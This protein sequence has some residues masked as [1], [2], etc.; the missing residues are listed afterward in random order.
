M[1]KRLISCASAGLIMLN[2]EL[3]FFVTSFTAKNT[4][5]CGAAGNN[6]KFRCLIKQ[7]ILL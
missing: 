4:Q 3:Q 5:I 2:K 6:S 7:D 1:N